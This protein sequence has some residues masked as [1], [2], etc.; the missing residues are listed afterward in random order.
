MADTQAGASFPAP[1]PGLAQG[2][3][4]SE[5]TGPHAEQ[6][7]TEPEPAAPAPPS[8]VRSGCYAVLIGNA[9]FEDDDL[10]DVPAVRRSLDRFEEMLLSP[11]CGW[12]KTQ[13]L[14]LRDWG[15]R[16]QLFKHVLKHLDK[17]NP[18][19]LLFLYVGHGNLVEGTQDLAMALRDS[20]WHW[21]SRGIDSLLLSDVRKLMRHTQ[22]DS[23]RIGIFDCCFSGLAAEKGP[24]LGDEELSRRVQRAVEIRGALTLTASGTAQA[25]YEPAE[26]GL[27]YYCR[28]FTDV[29]RE[30]IDG[31]GP[32]LTIRDIHDEVANRFERM[33]AGELVSDRRREIRPEPQQ[34]HSG[35]ADRFPFAVNAGYDPTGPGP[36]R[37]KNPETWRLRH[38]RWVLGVGAAA[39]ASLLGVGAFAAVERL[40]RPPATAA[41]PGTTADPGPSITR[42]L[43]GDGSNPPTGARSPALTPGPIST[44]TASAPIG[45]TLTLGGSA[46]V[47][48]SGDGPELLATIWPGGFRLWRAAD[49]AS[50]TAAGGTTAFAAS[51]PVS[52]AAFAPGRRL[53]AVGT[54]A[55]E[56]LL[57]ATTPAGEAVRLSSQ[58]DQEDGISSLSFSPDGTS[59]AS[60][61]LDRSVV[62]WDVS[63]PS[64]FYPL[65]TLAGH[66]AAVNAVAFSPTSDTVLASGGYDDTVRVWN[67]S[68]P[69][70]AAQQVLGSPG[71]V[72]WSLA[73]TPDGATLASG[74]DA[75]TVELW[76]M[77]RPGAA[78]PLGTLPQPQLDEVLGLACSRDFVLA[79]A[80][81]DGTVRLTDIHDPNSPVRVG[82][83]LT[84][85]PS[86]AFQS[87]AFTP[88]GRGLAVAD[89]NGLVRFWRLS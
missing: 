55:G 29:V 33:N 51:N 45:S 79:S 26:D 10:E 18:H 58:Q 22:P 34:V 50:V 61:A 17:A 42:L 62:V 56:V 82:P 86:V 49:L 65:T 24:F 39:G 89:R 25:V 64:Q 68:N 66:T 16:A 47:A 54:M 48:F 9:E 53:L 73:F 2:D 72:V 6:P 5:R 37:R 8:L 19:T 27:T 21:D 12:R 13:I 69:S 60:A 52:A 77:G 67:V 76:Q 28:F 3:P 4:R 88:D 59:L 78:T 36:G 30:G 74:T 15:N 43:T 83:P 41:R 38:R 7:A 80:S 70:L 75:G 71:G 57:Y 23:V 46:G 31:A 35:N 20:T 87:A 40:A 32:I 44:P 1:D 63:T 14:K 85:T 84:G 11:A 81:R